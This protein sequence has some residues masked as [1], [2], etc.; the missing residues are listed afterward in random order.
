[1]A[2][3]LNA[4]SHGGKES[5]TQKSAQ[6]HTLPPIIHV[7]RATVTFWFRCAREWWSEK[8]KSIALLSAYRVPEAGSKYNH[9][10]LQSMSHAVISMAPSA[11]SASHSKVL[12]ASVLRKLCWPSDKTSKSS[13]FSP[14]LGSDHKFF[15]QSQASSWAPWAMTSLLFSRDWG[16]G[17]FNCFVDQVLIFTPLEIIL[18]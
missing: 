3:L 15:L 13:A 18:F 8:W 16:K 7:S 12:D 2:A 1:M 10:A 5:F 17:A 4:R 6:K 14:W 9:F 11:P